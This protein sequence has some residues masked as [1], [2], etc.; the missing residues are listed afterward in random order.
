M[1]W[2]KSLR[3]MVTQRMCLHTGTHSVH[4][5]YPD[6]R[7]VL[8]G[9]RCMDCGKILAGDGE[10]FITPEPAPAPLRSTRHARR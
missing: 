3:R 10:P 5:V 4:N 8:L 7:K 6:G 9:T 1:E 2:L